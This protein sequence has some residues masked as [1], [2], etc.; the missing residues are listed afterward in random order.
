MWGFIKYCLNCMLMVIA[1]A[2]G[3]NPDGMTGKNITVGVLTLIFLAVI[4]LCVLA[5]IVF[6]INR[7]RFK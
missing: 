4:F 2:F 3:N 6:I 5:I 1:G 7:I